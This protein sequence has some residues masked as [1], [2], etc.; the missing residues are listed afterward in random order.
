MAPEQAEGR[1]KAIG[2]PT[3]VYGLGCILYELLAGHP[4]FRG[5]SQVETLKKVTADDPVPP[6]RLHRDLPIALEAIVLKCLAKEPAERYATAADLADDLERFLAG[7]PTRARPP[8][9][10][11]EM[12]RTV[13]RHPAA[14]IVPAIGGVLVGAMLIG[15][16]WYANR[17]DESR[18]RAWQRDEEARQR[19]LD[20][21][22]SH[23][24]ADLR[25]VPDY[26]RLYQTH[27][28]HDVLGRHRPGPGEEDLREFAWHHLWQRCHQE[29]RTLPGPRDVVYA[30]EFSPQGDLLA[31]A[32]KDGA[33][34]VWETSN[35][36]LVRRIE[37]S[38][39][40]VNV[41]AF[42]P[43][44]QA[45]A[46]VDDEGRLKLWETATGRC[47][48]ERPAHDGDAVVARFTHD[49][50][51]I[52]TGGRDDGLIKLWDRSSGRMLHAFRAS[53]RELEGALFSPDGSIL[54]I[55]GGDTIKLWRPAAR[56]L[57]ASMPAGDGV[58]GAAFSHDGS[59]LATAH[60]G[61]QVVR[62]WDV[63]S[64]RL[65][66]EFRGHTDGVFA[67]AFSGD[68]RTIVTGSDDQTIRCWDVATG[69]ERG[70][71]LGHI[72]RVWAVALS[73]DG[74]TVASAGGDGTV[75]LWDP[76]PP[77]Q[78]TRLPIAVPRTFG[79][80]S[81]GQTLLTFELEPEW[82]VARWDV[83]SGTLLGRAPLNLTGS[84][85]TSAFSRDGR[86]L[87][88][89]NGESSITL[90][91]LMTGQR[92]TLPD[93]AS[94]DVY[95][96]EFSPNDRYVL[97]SRGQ[98]LWD[99][100]RRRWISFPWATTGFVSFTPAG[101][102]TT[103]LRKGCLG[104]WDPRTG[105]TR[106]VSL[107]PSR[108]VEQMSLSPDGRLL[109]SAERY[110]AYRIDLWSADTLELRREMPGHREEIQCLTFSPD[111][112]TLASAGGDGVVK[113]WDAATGEEL[114]NL[115]GYTGPVWMVAF[116]PDGKALATLSST[117][118]DKPGE[119]VLW[120]AGRDEM[121]QAQANPAQNEASPSRPGP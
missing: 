6:R 62:L 59:R 89:A 17:F 56:T 55:V 113:L 121:D 94:R 28:A 80:T 47:L 79:F 103:P 35:W 78:R 37:A 22:R 85:A 82:S 2:P 27:I 106:A 101:E 111:G 48:L 57:L 117:G 11:G 45:I 46:T 75:K 81:D 109:A 24:V 120:R 61:D 64:R 29:R 9:R 31:G 60:E 21:R 96:L 43:D 41:A 36:R 118:R 102:L 15:G 92:Q 65:V 77:R 51:T 114:L 34:L 63:S 58:Q 76:E 10:W 84:N 7:E 72:A 83:R 12:T 97:V 115:E 116:S 4:P 26:L 20:L 18:P 110:N 13:R 66:R 100:S 39:T 3:D 25:Q 119:I 68:D 69:A 5:E 38:R 32:G 93:P 1:L 107:E 49:G 88:V 71:W 105:R 8:G 73:P 95:A 99:L 30:V 54:A 70:V 44:G 52:V 23:Y 112:K 108:G 16:R 40:E 91:D 33:V 74:R 90:C 19:E 104:W 14:L 86:Y 67:V 50:R 53:E 98:R 87:A 42:S